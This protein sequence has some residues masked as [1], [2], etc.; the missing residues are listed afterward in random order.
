MKENGFSFGLRPEQKIKNDVPGPNH[1]KPESCN[2]DHQAAY[3]FG[4]RQEVKIKNDSPGKNYHTDIHEIKKKLTDMR[5]IH[6]PN[7]LV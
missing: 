2:L 3:S 4:T 6:P 1:Y 7:T 5:T